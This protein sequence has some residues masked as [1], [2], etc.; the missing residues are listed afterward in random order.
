MI[1]PND[2]V[3]MHQVQILSH[4]GQPIFLDQCGKCGG[5]WFDQSELF[6]AKQGEAEKFE[7]LDSSALSSPSKV[8]N[9]S[10]RCP[11][12]RAAL[13]QFTDRSFPSG[14]IVARC[15]LC[16]GFWLNH[17]EF[18]EY[19]KNRTGL[20]RNVEVISE[21]SKLQD[22][23]ARILEQHNTGKTNDVLGRVGRFLSTPLDEQTM[24]PLEPNALSPG[25]ENA[26]NIIMNVLTSILSIF[27]F[28]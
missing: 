19:Q 9:S 2:N 21:N 28:K 7:Y 11:R 27:V 25:E 14:I 24:Q 12:D 5:I 20:H 3:A 6:R 23:I 4:Y 18:T 8:E 17:G 10:L 15:P 13:M 26:Y 1:C 16:D 22:R